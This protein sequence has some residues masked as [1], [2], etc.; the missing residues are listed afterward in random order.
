MGEP[1]EQR[2]FHFGIGKDARPFAEGEVCRH[3]HRGLLVKPA[4]HMKQQVAASERER[5]V[6]EFVEHDEVEPHQMIGDAPLPSCAGLH[7]QLVD[8]NR[9]RLKSAAHASSNAGRAMVIARYVL[10]VPVPPTR[11]TLRYCAEV[12]AALLRARRSWPW[13][14]RARR[15][16][17]APSRRL[18]VYHASETE[19]LL[20]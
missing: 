7:F 20:T 6:A 9:Q 17:R 19:I 1:V 15:Q 12:K 3:D 16:A 14:L 10:P 2:R 13:R 4:D 18:S 11:T 8:Q 5:Q